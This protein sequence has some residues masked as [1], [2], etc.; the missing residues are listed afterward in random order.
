M[1][2]KTPAE[3]IELRSQ[4][5]SERLRVTLEIEA[6]RGEI[7]ILERK[8]ADTHQ[9]M[10]TRG[11]RLYAAHIKMNRKRMLPNIGNPS[12]VLRL[13]SQLCRALHHMGIMDDQMVLAEPQYRDFVEPLRSYLAVAKDEKC[14][15]EVRLMNK[16][17]TLDDKKAEMKE[18]HER[19]RFSQKEEIGRLKAKLK[20]RDM[21]VEL[22][23]NNNSDRAPSSLLRNAALAFAVF[24]RLHSFS[25]EAEKGE[26]EE[27]SSEEGSADETELKE[28]QC[29]PTVR[30]VGS[31]RRQF[32]GSMA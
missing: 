10:C 28:F 7:G 27:D 4:H 1:A 23:A 2:P 32:V 22:D 26:E 17:L 14:I 29:R 8:M 19:K 16:L 11:I 6:L 5:E 12:C 9:R 20:S 15:A 18:A 3:L 25:N 31:S 21:V 30:Q 24:S 13:Q